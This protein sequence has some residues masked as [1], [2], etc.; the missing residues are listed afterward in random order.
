MRKEIELPRDLEHNS[1]GSSTTQVLET[2]RNLI[3]ELQVFETNNEKLKKAQEYQLEINEM[4]LC[5]I[6]TK[7]SPKDNETKKEVRKRSSKN[8][9]HKT[10]KEDILF[11]DTHMI[12]NKTS[13]ER[14]RKQVDHLECEFKKTKPS[15]FDGEYNTGEEFEAWLLY[16]K[17]YFQIYN[18]SSNM[19]V[20]MAIYNLKGKVS[21][22]WQDLK[23]AKGLKEKQIEWS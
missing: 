17:K 5:S 21:I 10:K 15:T 3:M 8:S 23:L 14:K 6:V 11:K 12:E 20:R 9:G 2:M 22:W 4:F 18:Y 1:E 16:I 19:K 7:K 13:T